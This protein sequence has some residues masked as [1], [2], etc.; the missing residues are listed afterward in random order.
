MENKEIKKT[1]VKYFVGGAGVATTV[2]LVHRRYELSKLCMGFCKILTTPELLTK[3]QARAR[4][5]LK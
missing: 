5:L 2:M 3:F 4:I 1:K